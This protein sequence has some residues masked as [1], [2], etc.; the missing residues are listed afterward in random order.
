MQIKSYNQIKREK[1]KKESRLRKVRR[2]FNVS[3]FNLETKISEWKLRRIRTKALK[4]EGRVQGLTL[5]G[6]FS[7]LNLEKG[8]MKKWKGKVMIKKAF[9]AITI[10]A[11]IVTA[12]W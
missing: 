5:T 9:A 4:A 3:R 10:V 6:R 7:R 1:K 11:V 8:F 12:Y 2:F